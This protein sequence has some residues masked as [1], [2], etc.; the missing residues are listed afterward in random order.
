VLNIIN[1]IISISLKRVLI[2]SEALLI[3]LLR[4]IIS[5][6]EFSLDIFSID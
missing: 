3:V 5:K 4:V 2:L 1:N 6:G